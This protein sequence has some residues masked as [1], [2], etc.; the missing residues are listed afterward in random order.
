MKVITTRLDENDN[1]IPCKPRQV[2]IT[3]FTLL[4]TNIF[5]NIMIYI[6]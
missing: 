1:F 4:I 3:K 6:F 5:M 2:I